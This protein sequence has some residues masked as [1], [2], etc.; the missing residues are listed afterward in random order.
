MI[1]S[2]AA[3]VSASSSSHTFPNPWVY[4]LVLLAMFHG[5]EHVYIY[6]EY[7]YREYIGPESATDRD[8]WV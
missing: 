5:I 3:P 4:P 6:R 7:I 8:F 1:L 2:P